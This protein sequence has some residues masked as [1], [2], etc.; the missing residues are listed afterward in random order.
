MEG[1]TEFRPVV[2]RLRLTTAG[3]GAGAVAH[4]QRGDRAGAGQWQ[5][6][7]CWGDAVIGGHVICNKST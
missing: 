2:L 7:V 4:L 5:T 3:A 6:G 1:N